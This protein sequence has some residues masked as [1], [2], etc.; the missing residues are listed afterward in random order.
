MILKRLR[1]AASASVALGG[2]PLGNLYRPLPDAE[3]IAVVRRAWDAGIRYFDTAPHYGNGLSER[4]MGAA[5]ADVPRQSFLL[6]TKVG[7]LL[8]A[9]ARA[10]SAQHGYVDVPAFVQAYDY[11]RAG[12][13]RSLEDSRQ[14]LGF[15]RI[16]LVYVHDLDRAT[17]GA[18]FERHFRALL[19]SGLPAL[20]EIKRAGHIGGYGIGVNGVAICLD[21]L[22]HADLDAILLAGRYTLADQSALPDLLPSCDRRGVALVVG[23]PFNSGI[24]ATGA[25]PRDGQAPYFDYAPAPPEIVSHVAA[26]EAV[27]EGHGV[28]LRAAALQFPAAHP[29]VAIVVAGARNERELDDLVAMRRF[30][31]PAG[32]W[33][34]L[35]QRGLIAAGAPLPTQPFNG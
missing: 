35:R 18:D 21:V 11:S 20:A 31:I 22:Q 16:D 7:R 6:S 24:L 29:A 28:P 30:P 15:D 4:R 9:D 26:I 32:F 8:Q 5:L 13:L 2:A 19:D 10:P 25:R 1:D 14:R 12:I 33:V 23:G 17:H 34:E 3:A 27:C